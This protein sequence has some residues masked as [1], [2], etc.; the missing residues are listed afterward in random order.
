MSKARAG[1]ILSTEIVLD[2]SRTIFETTPIEPFAAKGKSEPV[3]ASIVGPVLGT[4]ERPRRGCRSSAGTRSSTALLGVDRRRRGTAR[5]GSSRSPASAG[6]GKTRLVEEVIE[7]FAAISASLRARCEEYEASTPYFA[8]RA[9]CAALGLD[10]GGRFGRGRAPAPR[11]RRAGRSEL[12]PWIPLLGI[13]LGLDL[14]RHPET[15]PRRSASSASASPR[16]RCASS[17][18]TL[19]GAPTMLVVEDVHYIDEAS[20]TCSCAALAARLEPAAGPAR[21]PLRPGE[22]WAPGTTTICA[23]CDF[24]CCRCS[25]A[26]HGRDRRARHRGRAAPAPRRRRDRAPVGRQRAL[27][28][29]AARRGA[30]DRDGRVAAR[31]GRVAD[32]RRDRPA[33]ADATGRSSATPSVLGASFDPA[34]RRPRWATRSTWTSALARLHGLVEPEPRGRMRFRN[35][36]IRD[37]AYEG[38]PYRRRRAPRARRRDDRGARAHRSTRRRRRSPSTS[39]RRSAGT[40]RGTYCRLAGDRARAVAATSRRRGSTGGALDAGRHVRGVTP[41]ERA[42]ALVALGTVRQSAASLRPIVRRLPAAQQ[43]CCADGPSSRPACSRTSTR[44]RVRAGPWTLA[45]RGN[46]RRPTP[47][48]RSRGAGRGCGARMAAGAAQ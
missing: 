13:L 37:A 2:R 45:L 16:W 31:L 34:A 15:R 46:R 25:T 40:R 14:P 26:R 20:A 4:K 27:P 1:Q 33:L 39:T 28:V 10:A 24:A 22:T 19:A 30:R 43:H 8:L 11:G 9:P 21:H 47:R 41:R 12:V 44:A 38:L 32:R 17:C 23:A 42:D 18:T 48:G 3:R 5:A 7:P 36:L 35:T 29:R 6:I